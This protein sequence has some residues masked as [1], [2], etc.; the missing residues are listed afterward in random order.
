[1]RTIKAWQIHGYGGPEVLRL[2]AIP[3]PQVARGQ[4]LVRVKAAGVNGLDWRI[5]AG[6]LQRVY[7]LP[8]PAV[9]G[10]E[11]AGEVVAVGSG[12]QRFQVG[13]RVMGSVGIT[14]AYAEFIAVDEGKLNLIPASLS[15]V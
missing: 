11:L 1:M 3:M 12:A 15:D 6:L 13:D 10:L 2:N 14:G 9:L 4:V 8:L 5:Q 7:P